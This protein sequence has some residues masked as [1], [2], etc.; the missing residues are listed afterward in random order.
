[1][2]TKKVE[3]KN[4][5]RPAKINMETGE[6]IEVSTDIKKGDISRLFINY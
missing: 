4:H 3:Y 1:M 6:I 5:E 2:Y